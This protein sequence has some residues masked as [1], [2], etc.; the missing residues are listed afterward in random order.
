MCAI[1][2][3][4][5]QADCV[6]ADGHGAEVGSD[7]GGVVILSVAVQI[8]LIQNDR[9]VRIGRCRAVQGDRVACLDRERVA[10]FCRGP[11]VGIIISV[12]C[13]AHQ[14]HVVVDADH[15][16]LRAV[17]IGIISRITALGIAALSPR[18]VDIHQLVIAAG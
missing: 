9:T 15:I 1:V 4:D 10:S 6:S 18:A 14:T 17:A 16:A 2:V 3:R 11:F 8:P 13:I 12:V 5:L 7:A